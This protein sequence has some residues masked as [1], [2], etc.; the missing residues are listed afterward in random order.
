M[1]GSTAGGE[2]WDVFCYDG[3]RYQLCKWRFPTAGVG[4]T[5][6]FGRTLRA[7]IGWVTENGDAFIESG[8]QQGTAWMC[9]VP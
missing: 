9:P 1:A 7:R 4:G 5:T 3:P 2:L 8:W 6:I